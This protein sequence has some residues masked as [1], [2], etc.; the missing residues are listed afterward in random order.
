[1]RRRLCARA[2]HLVGVAGDVADGRIEL[3]QGDRE[4]V[5]GSGVHAA[6]DV[7]RPDGR[8]PA[9]ARAVA[10]RACTCRSERALDVQQD[11]VA[12]LVEIGRARS[13]TSKVGPKRD[14]AVA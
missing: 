9:I 5:G 10:S 8:V 7:A 12:L 11:A 14:T 4:A 6:F 13:L 2:A 1:M 3:R